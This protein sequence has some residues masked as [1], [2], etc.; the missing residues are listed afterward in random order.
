MN[1]KDAGKRSVFTLIEL[2]VV[3]AI[4]AVLASLLLPALQTARE[5]GRQVAC[6]NQLRQLD[7]ISREY[8]AD[9]DGWMICLED[10]PDLDTW[11]FDQLILLG[12][13]D[14]TTG[15]C[16]TKGGRI[17][18]NGFP[19]RAYAKYYYRLDRTSHPSKFMT[20]GDGTQLYVM[21]AAYNPTY[22]YYGRLL[23]IHNGAC[24]VI[25]ADGHATASKSWPEGPPP[26]ID[27]NIIF[28]KWQ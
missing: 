1:T 24:N 8:S 22:I 21:P 2:L 4:I 17:P 14:R 26:W 7:L 23:Y 18:C 12:Y 3:I 6:M 9:H 11:W 5:R 25:F 20:Y 13:M 27:E 15:F 10:Y 28:W 16:P 19:A